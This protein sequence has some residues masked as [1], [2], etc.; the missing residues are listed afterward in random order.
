MDMSCSSHPPD[1][2]HSAP[3]DDVDPV[4]ALGL[5]ALS[6]AN[7]PVMGILA[8]TLW[9]TGVCYMWPTMLALASE[10]FPKSGALG[11]GLIGTAG[12]LSIYFLLPEMGKIFDTAKVTA[13]GGDA[14]FTALTGDSLNAVL[15]QASA[16]S[17]RV[18]AFLPAVLLLLFGVIWLNDRR[19]GGFTP[20]RI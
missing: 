7:S 19:K 1:R 10:R 9:G 16:A 11:M 20:E 18:V 12:S 8:A 5:V 2:T 6:V 4:Q 13:A 14:A 15:A 17:F 3:A